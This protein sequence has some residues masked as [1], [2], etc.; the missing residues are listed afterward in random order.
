M[1]G[2]FLFRLLFTRGGE[3]S[4]IGLPP[5][6]GLVITMICLS[7]RMATT[8]LLSPRATMPSFNPTVA[9]GKNQRS[10]TSIL[11]PANR[12]IKQLKIHRGSPSFSCSIPSIRLSRGIP[13]LINNATF[14]L[15]NSLSGCPRGSGYRVGLWSSAP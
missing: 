5:T 6:V 13:S 3:F 10:K 12:H 15:Y 14:H 2:G 4:L 9:Y 7:R 8:R 11:A 1:I